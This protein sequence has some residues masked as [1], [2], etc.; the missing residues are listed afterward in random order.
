[1]FHIL[2]CAGLLLCLGC[3]QNGDSDVL[4]AVVEVDASI[5]SYIEADAMQPPPPPQFL[6]DGLGV[7]NARLAAATCIN[8]Q[9]EGPMGL[10]SRPE[11]RLSDGRMECDQTLEF[12]SVEERDPSLQVNACDGWPYRPPTPPG[13]PLEGGWTPRVSCSPDRSVCCVGQTSGDLACEESWTVCPAEYQSLGSALGMEI[14]VLVP[15]SECPQDVVDAFPTAL[16][17]CHFLCQHVCPTPE[18]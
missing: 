2:V 16:N 18:W 15:T 17:G 4:D 7:E 9:P 14:N 8:W 1:M 11:R 3:A 13:G 12:V 10:H 6:I 5:D